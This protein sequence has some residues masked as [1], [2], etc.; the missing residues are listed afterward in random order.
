MHGQQWGKRSSLPLL[1]NADCLR[2]L[3]RAIIPFTKRDKLMCLPSRV[4]AHAFCS[5][6]RSKFARVPRAKRAG[7]EETEVDSGQVTSEIRDKRCTAQGGEVWHHLYTLN[8]RCLGSREGSERGEVG[9]PTLRIAT[10]VHGGAQLRTQSD[11]FSFGL[12]FWSS[13]TFGKFLS[14]DLCQQRQQLLRSR[15]AITPSRVAPSMGHSGPSPSHSGPFTRL[16]KT[17]TKPLRVAPRSSTRLTNCYHNAF[18]QA[19][20]IVIGG[21]LSHLQAS[22]LGT[23]SSPSH[24]RSVRHP[25]LLVATGGS[26][27]SALRPQWHQPQP[28][29][30][31]LLAILCAITTVEIP[32]LPLGRCILSSSSGGSPKTAPKLFRSISAVTALFASQISISLANWAFLGVSRAILSAQ[33]LSRSFLGTRPFFNTLRHVSN[34]RSR[35]GGPFFCRLTLG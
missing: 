11:P 34:V 6:T 33:Q 14:P 18:P 17:F 20:I 31:E 21:H 30:R 15:W 35:S 9:G 16:L 12:V 23:T 8:F 24:L 10:L 28:Y 1:A 29:S 3:G 32:S 25:P 7:P 19:D 2:S 4:T 13:F 5:S 22:S 26:H 27:F